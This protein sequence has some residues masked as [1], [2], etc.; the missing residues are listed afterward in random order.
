MLQN[1]TLS[2]AIAYAVRIVNLYKFLAEQKSEF[3]MSK[4]LLRCGTSIGANISEAL[5]AE[6]TADFIH[7]LAIAQK[8]ANETIY[9][10]ILLN[11]TQYISDIQYESMHN[12]CNE[13]RK[14]LTSIILTTK[15]K[16]P[17]K[18]TAPNHKSEINNH[19]S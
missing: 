19:K 10:L 3:V 5:G 13:L 16:H 8:E 2:K 9:W 7:K 15:Q 6:S 1:P 18:I 11:Q 17:Q 14:I 12:D 4:Q